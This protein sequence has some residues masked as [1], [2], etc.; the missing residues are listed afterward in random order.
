MSSS[1]FSPEMTFILERHPHEIINHQSGQRLVRRINE[2][3]F[4]LVKRTG[5][6][7]MAKLDPHHNV[8]EKDMTWLVEVVPVTSF[9]LSWLNT[10]DKSHKVFMFA[11]EL[12]FLAM[13][14]KFHL[15]PTLVTRKGNTDYHQSGGGCHLHVDASLG[16][17]GTNWYRQMER[18]HRN[19]AVDYANRP[20]ARW[21]LAHWIGEGS[22]VIVD[23]HR[24]DQR[25]VFGAGPL[26]RDD[27]FSRAVWNASAIEPRFMCSLKASFLTFEFRI[28][29]MVD[30]ARQLRSAALLIKAWVDHIL[31]LQRNPRFTLTTEKW[32]T[33][34]TENGGREACRSWIKDI[35]GLKW[36]DYEEDFFERCYLMRLRHGKLE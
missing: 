2:W 18:F 4:I 10:A 15:V 14:E 24:L 1:T 13:R 36:A 32:D 22:R 35:L 26:T 23:R 7:M 34:A 11:L 3:L 8:H 19:L 31:N 17:W 33:Y 20:Y 16:D 12:L 9:Q 21:L 29:G 6:S 30:N 25:A 28:V 27:I 5:V